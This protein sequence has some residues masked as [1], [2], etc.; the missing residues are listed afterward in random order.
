MSLYD[1]LYTQLNHLISTLDACNF[2]SYEVK[3]D[4]VQDVIFILHKRI[5]DGKLEPDFDTIKSYSFISLQNA[6]RAYHK[7]EIK[8]ETPVAE[9]WEVKDNSTTSEDEEYKQYL[10]TIV[11]SYIQ[12]TKY[13]EFDKRVVE[14][15][16][17]GLE[18]TQI[19]I[20]TGLTKRQITK[21]KFRVKNKLKFDYRRLVKYIIKHIEN[22]N[23]QVPCF[24]IADAKNYLS[25]L[26]PRSVTYM[27]TEEG[28]ISPCGFY[29]EVLIKKK[30]KQ[31]KNE[32]IRKM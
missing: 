12:Q 4:L 8:R 20:E 26:K 16:L 15:L 6:C 27:I 29:I 23:I 19:Q 28:V 18:D 10:H 9:F 1:Q 31:K 5:E 22:K 21:H 7:K 25:H 24:T 3:K 2:V 17:D 11:K 14:L 30:R 32:Q 13:S